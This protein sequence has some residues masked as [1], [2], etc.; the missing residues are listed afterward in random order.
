MKLINS[1][2]LFCVSLGFFSTAFGFKLAPGLVIPRDIP[3]DIKT[4]I[5]GFYTAVD[6]GQGAQAVS[7]F[8]ANP[9]LVYNGKEI[10]GKANQVARKAVQII[11][12]EIKSSQMSYSETEQTGFFL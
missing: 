1:F 5:N 10:D 7:Y 3:G 4:F 12:M 6:A 2:T 8:S 9:K 11:V